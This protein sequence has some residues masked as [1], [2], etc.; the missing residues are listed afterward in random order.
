MTKVLE[1]ACRSGRPNLYF[2]LTITVSQPSSNNVDNI[3]VVI[4][5]HAYWALTK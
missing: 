2:L 5:A 1:V 4:M 3:V